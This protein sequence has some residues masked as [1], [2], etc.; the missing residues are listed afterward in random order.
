MGSIFRWKRKLDICIKR[1]WDFPKFKMLCKRCLIKEA[2]KGY[3]CNECDKIQGE[4][5][6]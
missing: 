2:T 4:I 6:A 3:Y 5:D 1:F